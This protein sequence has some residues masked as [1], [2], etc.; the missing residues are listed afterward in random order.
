MNANNEKL[1]NTDFINQEIEGLIQYLKK[2]NIPVNDDILRKAL[3]FFAQDKKGLL[4]NE[5]QLKAITQI[6]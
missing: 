4:P 6:T 1:P 2:E 3:G 5:E